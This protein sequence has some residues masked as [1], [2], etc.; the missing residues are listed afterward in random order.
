MLHEA[1]LKLGQVSP[2]CAYLLFFLISWYLQFH[3]LDLNRLVEQYEFF[4]AE[5]QKLCDEDDILMKHAKDIA[6]K[7]CCRLLSL[8]FMNHDKA[9]QNFTDNE[10]FKLA[11]GK[12]ND[13]TFDKLPCIDGLPN[14]QGISEH[15]I[16]QPSDVQGIMDAD[17]SEA[18]NGVSS[19]NPFYFLY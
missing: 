12:F 7:F 9:S 14:I 16:K 17:G 4:H 6:H 2:L 18:T 5:W 3:F 19:I 15:I 10:A 1:A 8:V 13:G 11:L